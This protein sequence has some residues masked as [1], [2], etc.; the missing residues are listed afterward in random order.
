MTIILSLVVI[1]VLVFFHELGHFLAAKASGMMVQEFALG[2]G[3]T[4]FSITRGE[5]KYALR[6][7]PIGGFLRVVGEENEEGKELIPESRRYDKKP[8]WMR[9]AFV[10]GGSVFNFIL[11]A[12]IFAVMFVFIGVPSTQP[13]IGSVTPDWPAAQ[14]GLQPGDRIISIA[15]VPVETWSDLPQVVNQNAHQPLRFVVNRGGVEHIIT[16]TPKIDEAS[17]RAMIGVGAHNIRYNIFRSL[18]LGAREMV[19]FTGEIISVLTGMLTG[20]TPAEG[21]GP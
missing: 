2:M 6:M 11:A 15:G 14:A 4:I 5:T 8:V 13:I 19:W 1:G 9:M 3:P 17:N 20:R 7:L 16:I 18:Y 21:A 12:L 10:A